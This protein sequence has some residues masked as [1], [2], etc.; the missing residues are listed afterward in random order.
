MELFEERRALICKSL[1]DW[2]MQ[3]SNGSPTNW[4]EL[5]DLAWPRPEGTLHSL[6]LDQPNDAAATGKTTSYERL[7]TVGAGWVR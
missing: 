2:R 7:G 4:K 1:N 5:S 3:S 6:P